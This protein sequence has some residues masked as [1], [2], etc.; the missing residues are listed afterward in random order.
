MQ[1]LLYENP[2]AFHDAFG[3]YLLEKGLISQEDLR[4]A[5]AYLAQRNQ[6]VGEL[7]VHKGLLSAEQ[8]QSLVELQKH[9]RKFIGELAVEQ[10]L[11]TRSTLDDLLFS[12]TVHTFTIGEALLANGVITPEQYAS[13]MHEYVWLEEEKQRV[14]WDSLASLPESD[15]MPVVARALELAFVRFTGQLVKAECMCPVDAGGRYGA[16]WS[17][18]FRLRGADWMECT[19]FISEQLLSQVR[20]NAHLLCSKEDRD[21][22]WVFMEIVARY[23]GQGLEAR[24]IPVESWH[25]L[26]YPAEK[27]PPR[28]AACLSLV[29]AMSGLG[30]V[31]EQPSRLKVLV[32]MSCRQC[33]CP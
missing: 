14:L 9:S 7:A 33:P 23:L 32:T 20:A 5:H 31:A 24:G 17:L 12:Q 30:Q 15:I 18:C 1:H 29:T 21:C 4:Q 26:T 10:G 11:L 28:R 8:V 6:R 27:I 19:L 3:R 16:C 2:H 25:V 13:V 22:C